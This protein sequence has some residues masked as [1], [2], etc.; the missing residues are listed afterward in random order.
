M[1]ALTVQYALDY[2]K[3]GFTFMALCP[4]VCLLPVLVD[5]VVDTKTVPQWMKTDLGGGDMADLTPEEGAQASLDIIFRPGR[6][7]NGQ[8]PKVLVKG[9]EK[10]EGNNQYDGTNVPW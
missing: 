9:W 7:L 4:G 3:E 8:M 1:D 10:A 2:E 6:E 5:N